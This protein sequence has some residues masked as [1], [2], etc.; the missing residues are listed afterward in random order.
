ML[1]HSTEQRNTIEKGDLVIIYEHHDSMKSIVVDPKADFSNKF[2]NFKMADWIGKPFGSKGYAKAPSSGWVYLLRPT[3]ELW[4]KVLLHRTQ[5]LYAADIALICTMLEL[6]PGSRVL[7]CGTGSGSLTHALAR[8]IAPLGHLHT[9]DFHAQRATMAAKEFQEH[10]LKDVVTVAQRDIEQAGFPEELHGQADAVFLDVPGPWK[11]VPS[12]ARCLRPNGVLATFSP[13]IE[14]VQKTREAMACASFWDVR[15]LE[16]LLHDYEVRSERMITD[17]EAYA[18]AMNAAALG[19]YGKKRKHGT[20]QVAV[21]DREGPDGA[22]KSFVLAKPVADGRGHTGYLV[23]AR[24]ALKS[25]G[26]QSEGTPEPSAN[27][28]AANADAPVVSASG[29][30]VPGAAQRAAEESRPAKKQN[31]GVGAEA[32]PSTVDLGLPNAEFFEAQMAAKYGTPKPAAQSRQRSVTPTANVSRPQ[33]TVQ[34]PSQAAQV[35]SQVPKAAE[36]PMPAAAAKAA[37]H[38]PEDQQGSTQLVAGD[39]G[40]LSD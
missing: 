4:T 7:E 40:V 29:G 11:A 24:R 14:Q 38:P 28:A 2:G 21:M 19:G 32:L 16:C 33:A 15:V 39:Y 6:R 10:G 35:Q 23:F 31:T 8:A 18:A 3:P 36:E 27:G 22:C 17:T 37:E 30:T 34:P 20:D 26:E 12:A 1:L 25:I 9:F 13:C 5:I